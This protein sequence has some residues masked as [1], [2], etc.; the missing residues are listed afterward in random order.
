MSMSNLPDPPTPE[1]GESATA[2]TTEVERLPHMIQKAAAALAAAT[3]AAEILEVQRQAEIIYTAAKHATRLRD[4]TAAADT[5]IAACRKVQADALII[6]TQAQC[7]L[8]NEY[9]AAQARGEIRK[10]GQPQ[11]R[12]IPQQNNSFGSEDFDLDAKRIHEARIIRNAEKKKPSVI[13]QALERKLQAGEEPLRADVRRVARDTITPQEPQRPSV[14]AGIPTPAARTSVAPEESRQANANETSQPNRSRPYDMID[15]LIYESEYYL[16]RAKH[17]KAR[18]EFFRHALLDM[19]V[20]NGKNRDEVASHIDEKAEA[21]LE[22][23]AD[24]LKKVHNDYLDMHDY[25][26]DAHP[27]SHFAREGWE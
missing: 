2:M 27:D 1:I 7:R 17:E 5:V 6:E 4:I 15:Y 11:K 3:T 10:A 9:D 19:A 21:E 20:S 14:A 24:Y 25:Y 22:K 26:V 23:Q 16:A 13:K 18:A 12:N 8:A